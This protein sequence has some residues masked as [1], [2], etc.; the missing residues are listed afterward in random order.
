MQDA[1]AYLQGRRGK[2]FQSGYHESVL[3][4]ECNNLTGSWYGRE[5]ARWSAWG[6][7]LLSES[8]KAEPSIVPAFRGFPLRIAKQ[9]IATMIIASQHE[10]VEERPDLLEFVRSPRLVAAVGDIALSVYLCGTS[11][12]R[13]TGLAVVARPGG[14]QHWL[15]EFA[16]PPFGYLLTVSGEPFDS[17]PADIGWFTT[18]GYDD[19]REVELAELHI[20]P[21]HEAFPADFRTSLE[22]RRDMIENILREQSRQNPRATADEIVRSGFG[23]QFLRLHGEDW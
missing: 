18:C 11:T 13:S 2:L 5:F 12:G 16:L 14:E 1:E 23:P 15:V 8:L 6:D 17:R 21:T 19:E 3:C 10:L 20:L 7:V 9:V 22:I 4:S